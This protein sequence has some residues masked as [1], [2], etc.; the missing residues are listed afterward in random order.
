M[1]GDAE[2]K[3][4]SLAAALVPAGGIVQVTTSLVAPN[5]T[6]VFKAMPEY[7]ITIGDIT[8]NVGQVSGEMCWLASAIMVFSVLRRFVG[9]MIVGEISAWYIMNLCFF[10]ILDNLLLNGYEHSV[11]KY[12]VFLSST[13]ITI[14]I[15]TKKWITDKQKRHKSG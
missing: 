2:K 12:A 9:F 4:L 10:D 6:D 8:Y 1:L 7:V 14:I 3:K 13:L 15:F 5:L 11:P